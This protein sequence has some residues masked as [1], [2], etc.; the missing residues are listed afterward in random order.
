MLYT[1]VNN[2]YVEM[3]QILL[4]NG[5]DINLKNEN[6]DDCSSLLS[7]AFENFEHL[8]NN[9]ESKNIYEQIINVL[10]ENGIDVAA[11]LQE[12]KNIIETIKKEKE[13]YKKNDFFKSKKISP[14]DFYKDHL[15]RWITHLKE[16]INL[17][18]EKQAA[19]LSDFIDANKS[20]LLPDSAASTA[21]M[22]S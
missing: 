14:S 12:Q 22:P 17:L 7:C 5:A 13:S 9:P 2:G 3:T 19:D 10:L 6:K 20:F 4:R 21:P 8:S 16:K 1:A 11:F 15:Q 18:S